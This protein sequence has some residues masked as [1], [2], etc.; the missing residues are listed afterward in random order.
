[1]SSDGTQGGAVVVAMPKEPVGQISDVT[2][3]SGAEGG[4]SPPSPD[5]STGKGLLSI[6]VEGQPPAE[7]ATTVQRLFAFM[8][9]AGS[10][11][12]WYS[13][14]TSIDYYTNQFPTFTASQIELRFSTCFLSA[15]FVGVWISALWGHYLTPRARLLP[16]FLVFT[17]AL[18][19]LPAISPL[20]SAVND[21]STTTAWG[22]LLS[23]IA[24]AALA[25]GCIESSLYSVASMFGRSALHWAQGGQSGSGV[26]ISLLRVITKAAFPQNETGLVASTYLYFG[27]S[28]ACCLL[29]MIMLCFSPILR[30]GTGKCGGMCAVTTRQGVLSDWRNV[31]TVMKLVR[32]PLTLLIV[33]YIITLSVVPVLI[34]SLPNNTWP[35]DSGWFP[36]IL[37]TLFS[38]VDWAGKQFGDTG[39]LRMNKRYSLAIL[40]LIRVFFIPIFVL[41][42]KGYLAHDLVCYALSL[43]FGWTS[44]WGSVNCFSFSHTLI[45]N[46]RDEDVTGAVMAIG[47]ATG[48]LVGSLLSIL[49][50]KVASN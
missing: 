24:I 20:L 22:L 48:L 3:K 41:V 33:Q 49:I 15:V 38:L 29:C 36:V 8:I 10:L 32:L 34:V 16:G 40:I 37:L 27:I 42:S 14:I 1:M 39:I 47:L 25:D 23:I 2:A 44:G 4:R 5:V 13:L 21:T 19:F 11:F 12:P 30:K 45:T 7:D 43:S 17:I 9:G 18:A 26:V 31:L 28:S 50:A 6:E 35:L 46:K